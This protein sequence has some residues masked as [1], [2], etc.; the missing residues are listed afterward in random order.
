MSHVWKIKPKYLYE[1][2]EIPNS[3]M[4]PNIF[5]FRNITVEPVESDSDLQNVLT[6][7]HQPEHPGVQHLSWETPSQ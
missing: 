4:D 1:M 6:S 5:K 3:H 7:R 2:E